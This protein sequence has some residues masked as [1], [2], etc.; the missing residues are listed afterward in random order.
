MGA[1]ALSWLRKLWPFP[2]LHLPPAPRPIWHCLPYRGLSHLSLSPLWPICPLRRVPL[3]PCSL[4]HC[5]LYSAD[6]ISHSSCCLFPPAGPHPSRFPFQ[7]RVPSH[8]PSPQG[9]HLQQV[10]L[11]SMVY[12]VTQT[13]APSAV[14]GTAAVVGSPVT[15]AL[16]EGR[17][18]PRGRCSLLSPQ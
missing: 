9:C 18:R 1:T 2:R 6:P 12:P 8:L 16:Q 4:S 5:H 10:A 13:Q 3:R 15:C 17:T 7:N 14:P 11:P